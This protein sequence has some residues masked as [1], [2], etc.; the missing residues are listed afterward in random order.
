MV[1]VSGVLESSKMAEPKIKIITG[2]DHFGQV[3]K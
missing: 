1:P 3:L 2:A